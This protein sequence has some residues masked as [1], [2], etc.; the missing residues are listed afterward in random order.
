MWS[1]SSHIP[2]LLVGVVNWVNAICKNVSSTKETHRQWW[3]QSCQVTRAGDWR[4]AEP[5]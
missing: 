3:F 4:A 1:V 5:L 2:M